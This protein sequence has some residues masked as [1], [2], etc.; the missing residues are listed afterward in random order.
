MDL[1]WGIPSIVYGAFGFLLMLRLGLR[2]SLG[3]AIV[4]V[5]ILELPIMTRAMDEVIKMVPHELKE[6]AFALGTTRYEVSFTVIVTVAMFEL[7]L[8]SF[9]RYVKLSVPL[10]LAFGV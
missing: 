4:T 8:P 2:E 3:A 6:V 10:K 9:A 7:T 1:L 5:A